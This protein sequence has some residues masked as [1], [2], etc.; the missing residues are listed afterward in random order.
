[1][2]KG[3][4]RKI[5]KSLKNKKMDYILQ[6]FKALANERRLKILELLIEKD[7]FSIDEISEKLKIPLTTTC[8]N[9]KTLERVYLVNSY[10]KGGNVFYILNRPKNH[11]YNNSIFKLIQTRQ[12][13]RKL[14][15]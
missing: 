6:V 2:G 9:L 11:P 1:M 4:G 13:R 12:E 8:R 14:L 15:H 5:I 7:N 10:R 3:K